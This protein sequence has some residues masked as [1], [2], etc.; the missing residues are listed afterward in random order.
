MRSNEVCRTRHRECLCKVSRKSIVRNKFGRFF[1][2]YVDFCDRARL[3]GRWPFHGWKLNNFEKRMPW[4]GRVKQV[5][6]MVLF[7]TRSNERCRIDKWYNSYMSPITCLYGADH[8]FF[9]IFFA[10]FSQVPTNL[11]LIVDPWKLVRW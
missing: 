3:F 5:L 11:F 8:T 4:A 6:S 7:A 2:L 1:F 9:W 10:S